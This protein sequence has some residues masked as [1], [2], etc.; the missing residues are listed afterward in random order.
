M[1]PRSD[2]PEAVRAR[3]EGG[4]GRLGWDRVSI[5]A[6]LGIKP[7]LTRRKEVAA[8]HRVLL[9]T[10][11]AIAGNVGAVDT[12]KQSGAIRAKRTGGC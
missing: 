8:R 12:C 5:E 6:V 1:P 4:L 3:S 7:P 2:R 9:P 11:G 10:K